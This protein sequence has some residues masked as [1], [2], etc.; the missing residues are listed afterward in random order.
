MKPLK[1]ANT[2]LISLN[3]GER[4]IGEVRRSF[5]GVATIFITA[6]F[7]VAGLAAALYFAMA[8]RDSLISTLGQSAGNKAA[9]IMPP[10]IATVMVLTVIGAAARLHVYFNNYIILTT[11]KL[12]FVYTYS[13]F[14]RSISKL[15]L[16]EVEDVT[17]WQASLL[18]RMLNY[19]TLTVETAGERAT[20][21]MSR[22]DDPLQA[23]QAILEVIG[24]STYKNMRGDQAGKAVKTG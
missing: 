12:V 13:L 10:L 21:T 23:S 8:H 2:R 1:T 6:L 17:V 22:M 11:R 24:R 9:D 4:I 14:S 3:K 15:G 16:E 19:G 18:P 5:V 20:L 7:I